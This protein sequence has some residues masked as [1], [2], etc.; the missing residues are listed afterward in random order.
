MKFSDIQ[1]YARILGV[2]SFGM[3]KIDLIKAIQ[4]AEN[5]IPCYGTTRVEHCGEMSCLWR[6]DCVNLYEDAVS[7]K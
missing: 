5:N 6:S 2:N 1:K 3:K 7:A 4:K